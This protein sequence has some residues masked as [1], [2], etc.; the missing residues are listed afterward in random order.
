MRE[1]RFRWR[2]YEKRTKRE[3]KENQKKIKR[4]P[5]VHQSIKQ[6]DRFEKL[7]LSLV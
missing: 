1:Y 2:L 6:K 4:E 3:A 7:P 5:K